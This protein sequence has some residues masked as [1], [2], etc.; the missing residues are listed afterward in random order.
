MVAMTS[1]TPDGATGRTSSRPAG[2]T[3]SRTDKAGQTRQLVLD[4]AQR[5]FT[6]YGYDAT[7]LQMIADEMGVTKA[8]VYY[9]FRTKADILHAIAAVTF[10]AIDEL[11]EGARLKTGRAARSRYLVEGFVDLL[12]AKRQM[13]TLKSSDPAIH[14]ELRTGGEIMDLER[15]VLHLL[16]GPDPTP[17]QRAAH[18]LMLAVP[19]IVPA[20]GELTDDELRHALVRTCLRLLAVRT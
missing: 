20:L 16:S 13:S 2:R 18:L 9:Y 19:E 5:L 11:I 7:S 4:T 12:V 15:R 8:A 6:Q 3:T 17:E 10:A 14:R 1:A